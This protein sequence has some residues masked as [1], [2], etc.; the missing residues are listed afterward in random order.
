MSNRKMC[1]GSARGALEKL[2]KHA[3]A[4]PARIDVRTPDLTLIAALRSLAE[5]RKLAEEGEVAVR[6]LVRNVPGN[7]S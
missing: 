3:G 5:I 4:L 1:A 6:L 2:Y 7:K